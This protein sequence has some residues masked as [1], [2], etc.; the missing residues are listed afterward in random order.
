M[1]TNKNTVTKSDL[2]QRQNSLGCLLNLQ[3]YREF[4]NQNPYGV[5]LSIFLYFNS[6]FGLVFRCLG[7]DPEGKA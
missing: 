1:W 4:A 3:Y 2:F 6:A 5:H 7:L